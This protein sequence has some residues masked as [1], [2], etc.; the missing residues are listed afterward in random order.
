M[1]SCHI[2]TTPTARCPSGLWV[3]EPPRLVLHTTVPQGGTWGDMLEIAREEVSLQRR[4]VIKVLVP[5]VVSV[6]TINRFLENILYV[7]CVSLSVGG[8]RLD[9]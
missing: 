5:S 6:Q 4:Q 8:L 1:L 2:L 7:M 9:R 3:S